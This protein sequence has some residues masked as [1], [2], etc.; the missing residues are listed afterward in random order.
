MSNACM[1]IAS[2]HGNGAVIANQLRTLRLVLLFLSFIL[3]FYSVQHMLWTWAFEHMK[4]QSQSLT[5]FD[6]ERK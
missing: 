3:S 6:I 2:V 1:L 4:D 5:I